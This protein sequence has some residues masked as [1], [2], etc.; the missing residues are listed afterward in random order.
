M[1]S[2]N[3]FYI[4]W[5]YI[6]KD[7]PC[8]L[9]I[10]AQFEVSSITFGKEP[11]NCEKSEHKSLAERRAARDRKIEAALRKSKNFTPK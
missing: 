3:K 4:R 5:G 1:Y 7:C 10:N 2:L 11:H 6:K 8:L 9:Y